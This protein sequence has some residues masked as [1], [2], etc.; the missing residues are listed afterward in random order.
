MSLSSVLFEFYTFSEFIMVVYNTFGVGNLVLLGLSYLTV[1]VY[2]ARLLKLSPLSVE[3]GKFYVGSFIRETM[4]M[5]SLLIS[6]FLFRYM[7]LWRGFMVFV[8]FSLIYIMLLLPFYV[9]LENMKDLYSYESYLTLRTTPSL[10]LFIEVP[11]Y[12]LYTYIES[13]RKKMHEPMQARGR[14]LKVI[15]IPPTLAKMWGSRALFWTMMFML[16]YYF[17]VFDPSFPLIYWIFIVYSLA[18][19][20]VIGTLYYA[21][22]I[23][24]RSSPCLTIK[25][26]N[27]EI[28]RGFLITRDDDLYILKTQSG[29]RLLLS[30]LVVEVTL[31]S[32]ETCQEEPQRHTQFRK[33]YLPLESKHVFEG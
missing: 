32:Q 2:S 7:S 12:I 28:H 24:V 10:P 29:D 18:V 16:A 26:F 22:I 33:N 8:H 30:Q 27:G 21:L 19:R 11:Y 1:L 13:F 31:E 17:I 23:H 25:T 4:Y 9:L 5:I 20:G 15:K 3:R 14:E 6:L